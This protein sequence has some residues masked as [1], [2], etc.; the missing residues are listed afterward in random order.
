M[1]LQ[2][3]Q[4]RGKPEGSAVPSELPLT[5]CTPVNPGQ[6]GE[7]FPYLNAPHPGSP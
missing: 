7:A 6:F 5:D 4:C 3:T 1:R 2:N